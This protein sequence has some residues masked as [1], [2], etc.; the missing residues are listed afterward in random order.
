MVKSYSQKL[1]VLYVM[2]ILL[3]YSDEEHPISQAEISERLNAY[4][5]QADRKS[6]YDDI[7]VL[8]EFGMEIENRRSKPAGFYVAE[9]TFELPELKLLVDAVQSSKFITAKKSKNGRRR[10][11]CICAGTEK[12]MKSARGA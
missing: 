3:R 2:R 10:K 8:N 1:R 6:I 12:P 9:R 11:K 5:I 7:K 4:G